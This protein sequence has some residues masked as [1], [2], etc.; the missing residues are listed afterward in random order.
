VNRRATLLLLAVGAA[1]VGISVALAPRRRPPIAETPAALALGERV[2]R[3]KCL[4]C[5]SDIPI[6]ARL[7]GW[8][9]ERAY[10]AI[11]KLPE[12]YPAMPEF[13]GTDDERRALAAYLAA[14]GAG[15]LA[16]GARRD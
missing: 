9:P 8:T 3:D 16:P 12:L 15:R 13:F 10:D 2:F 11:G 6:A 1:A 4:H 5:H 14:V 7:A